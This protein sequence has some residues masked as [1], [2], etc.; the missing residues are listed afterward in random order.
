MKA[1]VV[2]LPVVSSLVVA[3]CGANDG[4]AGRLG[5]NTSASSS[6]SDTTSSLATTSSSSRSSE[7]SSSSVGTSSANTTSGTITTS[8]GSS[9]SSGSSSGTAMP[10]KKFVGNISARGSIP[11]GNPAGSPPEYY[12]YWNQ[13]S[14]ENEGK[15]GS[16]QSS[17]P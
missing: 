5:P 15:W 17:V 10:T 14:P 3:A 2:L 6:H 1:H 8:N 7:R 11:A 12:L 16:V 13:F 9:T 4:G